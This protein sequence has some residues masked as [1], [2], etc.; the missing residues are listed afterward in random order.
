MAEM[1]TRCPQCR[2]SFRIT[3]AQIQKARGAVRCGSC[4]HIFN[5]EKHLIEGKPA[6]AK[7]PSK[8]AAKPKSAQPKPQ[9]ASLAIEEARQARPPV[10]P[11]QAAKQK[12]HF[13]QAQIDRESEIDD[14]TL[15]SDNMDSDA[16]EGPQADNALFIDAKPQG[17][18]LFDREIK[19][20]RE[21]F[22]DDSDESW[23]ESLL[24]EDT[25]PKTPSVS[26]AKTGPTAYDNPLSIVSAEPD[27]EL[28]PAP[29][30]DDHA[31]IDEAEMAHDE[32]QRITAPEPRFHLSGDD[33]EQPSYTERLRAYDT[34]RSAMLMGIDPEP[35]EMTEAGAGGWRRHLL[36]GGL[37]LLAVIVLI[38]QIAWLQFD[39]LSRTQPYRDYYQ[40][41]C[42][43]LGC[44]LPAMSDP[45]RIRAFNLVVRNHPETQ[46]ALMVDAIILN[47]A[48]FTQ[49]Y[50]QLQLT[51]TDIDG[52]P[53]ASRRFTPKEYLRGELSGSKIMPRNQPIHLSLELLDPGP[54][55]VNYR[56]DI[57]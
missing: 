17:R 53:V 8:T 37:S 49:A 33:D 19:E 24:E 29:S 56:L 26:S 9:Q 48:A 41:A 1:V 13:D 28:P 44:Q 32:E 2:T 25:D 34:E 39:R 35:V 50:P 51:F 12:L 3:A 7:T 5:A 43:L 47:N 11:P 10:K 27:D 54:E 42:N 36:W 30:M 15:I 20:Q 40:T 21:E 55:A 18:S 31:S 38:S 16:S 46:G 4:L 52:K 14:D 6:G 45:S 22:V 23:A 57:R